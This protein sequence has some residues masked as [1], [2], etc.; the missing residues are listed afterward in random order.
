V[1]RGDHLGSGR[2]SL[3]DE[4][5]RGGM[6]VVWLADDKTIGRRVAIKELLL[7][8]GIPL[9]ERQV[10]EQRVLREARTAGRL[11]DP[12][13]VTVHDV[14]QEGGATFIVMEL[15][16]APNL[17]EVI[18]QRGA[19]PAG[20]ALKVAEQLLLALQTAHA[21]GVIHR[22][23]KPS[24]V[25]FAPNGRVKLT[26]FGIAQTTEDSRLTVSGMLV[27]SPSYI[28][29]ER[30]LG[31]DASPA[32]DLWAL[33]A[34]LFFAVEGYGAYDRQT[35]AATIQAIMNE[36][37]Q[38]RNAQG[39]LA[40][41][42]MGLLDPN[43]DTRLTAAQA[44]YLI[45][46]A[47]F[48]PPTGPQP[49]TSPPQMPTAAISS[50]SPNI[51]TAAIS[52]APSGGTKALAQKKSRR[53]MAIAAGAVL[54]VAATVVTLAITGVL[55]SK[56]TESSAAGPGTTTSSSENA[57]SA[58]DVAA[59]ATGSTASAGDNA[60]VKPRA[61]QSSRT[62]GRGGEITAEDLVEHGRAGYCYNGPD[63]TEPVD[64]CAKPHDAEVFRHVPLDNESEA[65]PGAT[66]ATADSE[67]GCGN[68][69]GY[70]TTPNKDT[71]LKLWALVPSENGWEDGRRM[72][73]CVV[74][75]AD[76][77]KL[78]GSVAGN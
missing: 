67:I 18:Q 19:L 75:R 33:G 10:F 51:Q 21:A 12:G 25:M 65:W 55:D 7:P 64:D 73:L 20:Q 42:I 77:A 45:D 5:G 17:S 43:P 47:R 23:V 3:L 57:N 66:K 49:V 59:P 78:T 13:I 28:S 63:L 9:A 22:D 14:M 74:A 44:H 39:P 35:T 36:R 40:E 8:A 29:P 70:V 38:V 6:G 69:F 26:D 72:A 58:S 32:S 76:G 71:V 24:N 1:K 56:S 62:Y 30:L 46:Q 37:A 34:T 53:G 11:S 52:N 41:L 2:Y 16:E 31:R 61:M 15:I 4:L 48:R 68:E 27:G 50:A 54:V 60:Y